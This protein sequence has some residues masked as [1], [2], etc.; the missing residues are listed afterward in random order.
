MGDR[1]GVYDDPTREIALEL[2]A[3]HTL[4]EVSR[5]TGISR[6]ALREWR[7][8]RPPRSKASVARLDELIGLTS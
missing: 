6:A 8:G 1:R 4:S 3:Q 7:G 2:L 5:R